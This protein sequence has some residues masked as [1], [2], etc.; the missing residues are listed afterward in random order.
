MAEPIVAARGL[1]KTYGKKAALV[2]I[3][4]EVDA[5]DV[6]G[7][8]GKNGA[9]KTTLLETLLGFS[10]PTEGSVA[11]FGEDCLA[12]SAATKGPASASCRSRTS[13]SAC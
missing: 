12:L 10:P 4:A 9:G 8:L 13:C 6:I 7:V 3:S 1:G 2:G 11:F 5:G